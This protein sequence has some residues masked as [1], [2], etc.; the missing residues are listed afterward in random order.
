MKNLNFKNIIFLILIFFNSPVFAFVEEVD[1]LK[2]V[3]R[4]L[5]DAPLERFISKKYDL[6]EIYFENQSLKTFSIPG[7]S[8]DLG[9]DYSS[10]SEIRSQFKD[11]SNRKLAVFNIAAGA[12]S[13]AL[14][15]IAKSASKALR[16]VSSYRRRNITLDDDDMYLSNNK[17]Y[18]LYP[19]D[20]FSLFLFVNK[21]LGQAPSTMRFICHDED[22][23]L[24]Y[25]V[26]NN[27]IELQQVIAKDENT[28]GNEH[29]NLLVVPNTEQ[30][31]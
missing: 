3:L 8:L 17:T 30:Y 5:D 29:Q 24:N 22:N 1:G 27:H 14:G 13:I 7:Y 21:N 28:T 10:L 23:N 15:G 9:V 16:S 19:R 2:Y 4:K 31:K 6:Y 26:I 11:K 20:G 12:A 18:I 25:I